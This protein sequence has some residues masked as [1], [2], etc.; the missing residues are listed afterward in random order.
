MRR[1]R[2]HLQPSMDW[3]GD[4]WLSEVSLKRRKHSAW[5]EKY[6][7]CFVLSVTLVANYG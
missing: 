4:G 3:R 7:A 6:H 2:T 5:A 1:Q